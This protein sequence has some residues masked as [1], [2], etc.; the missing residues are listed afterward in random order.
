MAASS[1]D[2]ILPLHQG[3]SEGVSS[4]GEGARQENPCQHRSTAVGPGMVGQGV[5]SAPRVPR[6]AQE[7]GRAHVVERRTQDAGGHSRQRLGLPERRG[8]CRVRLREQ[9]VGTSCLGSASSYRGRRSHNTKRRKT[10]GEAY[11]SGGVF[12]ASGPRR[13]YH[14]STEMS[15]S[16]EG[17]KNGRAATLL[18]LSSSRAM[19][20]V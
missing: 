14:S 10:P 9:E 15:S 17:F 6:P 4:T 16:S 2:P 3:L 8:T 7:P 18:V 11:S 1:T 20:E 12:V 19:K 13:R 5:G